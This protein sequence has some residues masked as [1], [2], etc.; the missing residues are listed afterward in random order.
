M[1]FF[2]DSL[3]DLLR[4]VPDWQSGV[5]ICILALLILSRRTRLT[6]VFLFSSAYLWGI[7]YLFFQKPDVPK[8]YHAV[9]CAAGAVIILGVIIHFLRQRPR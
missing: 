6:L 4:W 1:D 9:F 2:L 3:R 8:I 5:Y 7:V